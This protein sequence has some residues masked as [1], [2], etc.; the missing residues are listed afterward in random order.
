MRE[1]LQPE[2]L[3]SRTML[4]ARHGRAY[5]NTGLREAGTG[6]FLELTGQPASPNK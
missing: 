1:V 4:K 3:S 2:S 6:G 5:F